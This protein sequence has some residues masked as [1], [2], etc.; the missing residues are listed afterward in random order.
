MKLKASSPKTQARQQ[1]QQ[2]AAIE[3]AAALAHY[4]AEAI[5]IRKNMERLRALRL[6]KESETAAEPPKLKGKKSSGH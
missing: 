4:E 1:R 6:A 2:R 3:G 5:A